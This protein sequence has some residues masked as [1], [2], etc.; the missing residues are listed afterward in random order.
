MNRHFEYLAV[1]YNHKNN[2]AEIAY[3]PAKLELSEPITLSRI[4]EGSW[5]LVSSSLVE[6]IA[7]GNKLKL[8]LIFKR[9]R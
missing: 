4:G 3:R 1:W 5:E 8:Y 6:D 7:D 2:L 9:E